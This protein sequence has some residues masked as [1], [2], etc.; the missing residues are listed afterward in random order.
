MVRSVTDSS[1]VV[2]KESNLI[3]Y[4]QQVWNLSEKYVVFECEA[5]EF[6]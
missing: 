4:K 6:K 3:I 2:V 1:C 5:R